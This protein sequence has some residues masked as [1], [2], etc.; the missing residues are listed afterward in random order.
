M[1]LTQMMVQPMSLFNKLLIAATVLGLLFPGPGIA[2]AAFSLVPLSISMFFSILASRTKIQL[3]FS[4]VEKGVVYSYVALTGSMVLASFFMPDGLRQG[5][6]MY[7]LFPPAVSV[8]VLTRHWGGKSHEVFAF[9]VLSYSLSILLVPI[10]AYF[11]LGGVVDPTT[12]FV[13]LMLAFILPGAISLFIKVDDK[14]LMAD[15]SAVFLAILFYIMMAKSQPWVVANWQM[16]LLYMVPLGLLNA[17]I[18]YWAY[19]T[20]KDPDATLYALF[21]NGG[22]AAGVSIGVLAP[23]AIAMISAKTFVDVAL[24]LGFGRLWQKRTS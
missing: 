2:V 21:K 22:A 4:G 18:G 17:A 10:A 19:R 13:Q 23:A 16:L 12:L 7:A 9:Q 6:I 8:L 3:D 15:L 24:I 1:L 5:L 11:L 20:T 14:E